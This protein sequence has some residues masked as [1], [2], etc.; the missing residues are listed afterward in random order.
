MAKS[1]SALIVTEMKRAKILILT[2]RFPYPPIGG[3]RLRIYQICKHLSGT[4]DLSLLSMCESEAEMESKLPDDG[5]FTHVER[6]F[7]SSR[8]RFLG[9]LRVAP[10]KLPF[11][12]GYYHNP[13]FLMR[14]RALA[15]AHEGVFAHL[16]RMAPYVAGYHGVKILEMTDAIS[17]AYLRTRDA[18]LKN[19]FRSIL[20]GLEMKRLLNYE[21][22]IVEQFDLVTL[23]S[24]VDRD[25]L[26]PIVHRGKVLICTNGVDWKSLPFEY[27][28]DG[29][30][31][32]F[33]G[34]NTAYH[35]IDALIYFV[36]LIF[37]IV[38]T[39]CQDAIFKV[40]GRIDDRLKKKLQSYKNVLV[41]GA[42]ADIKTCVRNA[43][44][45]VCPTRF[46]AGVQNKLLEYMSLGIPSVT[47]LIGLEGLKAE[48]G[49]DILVANSPEEW[50]NH[51]C[52]LLENP[53]IGKKITANART[54]VEHEHSWELLLEPLRTAIFD[55]LPSAK[56]C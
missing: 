27:S 35:N 8:R 42:I 33:I 16:I 36:E 7:H 14:F 29:K 20:Y 31:I 26:F 4:F 21:R 37:P 11:Q 17:L 38:R 30:T 24:P 44:V 3:D 54:Y 6:V 10:S 41:T 49:K 15:P 48:P 18:G 12:I 2:P 25:F 5:I 1:L 22:S 28:P 50:A 56:N 34:N 53:E 32:I 47:S 39:R 9:C 46:G 40:V 52:L 23:V 45:G 13:E 51:I 55:N 19:R 43:S